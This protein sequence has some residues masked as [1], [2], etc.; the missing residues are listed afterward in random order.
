MSF[1]VDRAEVEI[2]ASPVPAWNEDYL[3]VVDQPDDSD[4]QPSDDS[5]RMPEA[6]DL[7]NSDEFIS[8]VTSWGQDGVAVRQR[9]YVP[10]V[11]RPL[12]D[13]HFG[14]VS[15]LDTYDRYKAV[16]GSFLI[17]CAQKGDDFAFEQ[18]HKNSLQVIRRIG[19]RFIDKAEANEVFHT[20][21]LDVD[22][23]VQI[24][25][26]EVEGILDKYESIY[27]PAALNMF[28]SNQI[29]LKIIDYVRSEFSKNQGV[30]RS[31]LAKLREVLE[32]DDPN[33]TLHTFVQEGFLAA[34]QFIRD[35]RIETASISL[36]AM[37]ECAQPAEYGLGEEDPYDEST[38]EA[39]ISTEDIEADYIRGELNGE[40]LDFIHRL[41][42]NEKEVLARYL[43]LFDLESQTLSE[44]GSHMGFSES[45]A[46]QLRTTAVRRI[47]TFMENPDHQ[48]DETRAHPAFANLKL[49]DARLRNIDKAVAV[50]EK[51]KNK[52]LDTKD[53]DSLTRI[54]PEWSA[55][56]KYEDLRLVAEFNRPI[57]A[58][59]SAEAVFEQFAHDNPD[60][61][62]LMGVHDGT[63]MYISRDVTAQDLQAVLMLDAIVYSHA[64]QQ[65]MDVNTNE[66]R[67]VLDILSSKEI[68]ILHRLYEPYAKIAYDMKIATSTVRTHIHNILNKLDGVNTQPQ[69]GVFAGKLGLVDLDV[70][71][72]ECVEGVGD[73]SD[74]EL[75]ILTGYYGATYNRAAA[76]LSLS[77]STLRTH[78]HNIFE[79]LHVASKDQ[80]AMVALKA[81]VL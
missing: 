42:R 26:L 14:P 71:P 45:R 22:D 35:Q 43:G 33:E 79:K 63:F 34:P 66:T 77:V 75:E 62:G 18:V 19:Q 28:L 38:P 12:A 49:T 41:P 81:G 72:K 74:R 64:K 9:A 46:S 5:V 6:G 24:G 21:G 31:K 61:N 68:A 17:R 56:S 3:R 32:S 47:Q 48:S 36:D 52:S 29:T 16:R 80:A 30:S 8:H 53:L 78:W 23:F 20:E 58:G 57:P 51:L 4:L 40:L 50:L 69:L 27:Q 59:V 13:R 73:L 44:V 2:L 76:E 39:L 67:A 7:P 10:G 1:E 25:L 55:T 65:N 54:V 15:N 60:L 11:A 37:T 70:I